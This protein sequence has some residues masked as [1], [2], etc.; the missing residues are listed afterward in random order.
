MLVVEA[1][2]YQNFKQKLRLVKQY[3][4]RAKITVYPNYIYVERIE[5]D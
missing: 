5:G 4:G 2:P 1:I 3:V